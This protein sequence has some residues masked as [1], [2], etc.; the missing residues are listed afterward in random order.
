[1]H[2]LHISR[3]APDMVLPAFARATRPKKG[4]EFPDFRALGI[5]LGVGGGSQPVARGYNAAG[6][7]ITQTTDGRDLNVLWEEFQETARIAN[8]DRQRIIDFL[9]FP[10]TQVI[11][12]VPQAGSGADFEEASEYGEPVGIRTKLTYFSLAYDF[13]WYDLAARFTWQFL[14]DASAAQV[15]QINNMAIEADSRNVFNKVL[16][17]VFN[18]TNLAAT[19][20]GQAY[21][22]YKFYNA[23]GTVPPAYKTY[24]HDGTH[25]HYYG[26]GAA[27]LDSGDIEGMQD[28]L[29]HHGYSAANGYQ[30]VLMANKQQVD[31]MRTWRVNTT[32]NNAAVAKY[33]WIPARGRE[34][35]IF[36]TES[37]VLGNQ[38]APT[39]DGLN[40]AGAYG[41]FLVVEE[42]YIPAGYLFAFATGGAA[43]LNNPVGFRE[44]AN[45]GLRG[46]RLVK[47]RDADYPLIDSFYQHGFGT[48]IRQRGAGVVVQVVAS[49]TYTPPSQYA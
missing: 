6:D 28:H 48:G 34:N 36:L 2:E 18:A 40:V 9:T 3:P 12:D 10:V 32:N 24:T 31:V 5:L 16:R 42:D 20:N 17:T 39:L 21:T 41:N 1:M 13:K 46:F 45:A 25:T 49:T 43:N 44:H 38:P 35:V 14:A 26:T 15:E 22:V 11:E 4:L 7:I 37:Q 27:T 8:E 23:D 47:G 33:D 29:H 19:I 30:L